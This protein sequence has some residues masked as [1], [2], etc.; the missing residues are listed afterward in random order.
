MFYP[1]RT[2]VSRR[3]FLGSSALGLTPVRSF[4]KC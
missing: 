3:V 2:G 1:K 4:V